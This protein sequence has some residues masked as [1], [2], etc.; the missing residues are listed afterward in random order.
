MSA[1]QSQNAALGTQLRTQLN[2]A[3]GL[4]ELPGAITTVLNRAPAPTRR[5]PVDQKAWQLH[6]KEEDFH[7]WAKKVE[8]FVSGVFPNVRGALSFAV[9]SQDVVTAAAVACA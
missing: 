3:Q 2:I 8:N 5:M 6:H 4:A 9:E 1:L 7:V